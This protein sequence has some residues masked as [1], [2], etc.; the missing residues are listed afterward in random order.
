MKPSGPWS[1]S[2]SSSIIRDY[3]VYR[4]TYD[5]VT[6]APNKIL[7]QQSTPTP[8]NPYSSF[9]TGYRDPLYGSGVMLQPHDGSRD[10]TV[11][12]SAHYNCYS[13]SLVPIGG[14]QV[15][16]KQYEYR[17]NNGS[18]GGPTHDSVFG[19]TQ[20]PVLKSQLMAR[21]IS[22]A[23]ERR[24]DSLVVLGEGRETLQMFRKNAETLFRK[25]IS[26]EEKLL[27]HVIKMIKTRDITS[28][29]SAVKQI[30]QIASD[31]WLEFSFGIKPLVSDCESLGEAV[32]EA[33]LRRPTF[34]TVVGDE[35]N[36]KATV[37]GTMSLP[38]SGYALQASGNYSRRIY[39]RIGA[40]YGD[41]A[42]YLKMDPRSLTALF[43][44]QWQDI[45]ISAWNLIPGSF[46]ADYFTN[47]G[48]LISA[49]SYPLPASLYSYAIEV[50]EDTLE[51]AASPLATNG[52][53]HIGDFGK[54]SYRKFS[55]KRIANPTIDAT[56]RFKSWDE[57]S[58]TK[59][60]NLMALAVM[61]F[62][63]TTHTTPASLKAYLVQG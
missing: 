32:A 18:F 39:Y 51:W 4:Y 8:I 2:V 14:V 41:P 42:D 38:W 10:D 21:F 43:G 16:R 9:R 46:L 50:Q 15:K 23:S 63:K 35:I 40:V 37:A 36:H 57:V 58:P 5:P 27:K 49:V 52:V 61:A 60:A 54:G 13:E 3:I 29:P 55:W 25:T 31:R 53:V 20:L 45:G 48:D 34:K 17:G 62:Q 19:A 59:R 56:F 1:K 44:L 28:G 30:A 33:V 11:T 47:I 7:A 24:L 12:V 26:H 6:G 22:K